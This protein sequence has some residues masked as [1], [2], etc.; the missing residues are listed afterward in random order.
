MSWNCK[1]E[2]GGR[3][4]SFRWQRSCFAGVSGVTSRIWKQWSYFADLHLITICGMLVGAFERES[5]RKS[6]IVRINY[7]K[8][9]A[10]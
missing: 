9:Q 4:F 10:L 6:F 2:P 1:N 8:R 5:F 7:T 3:W